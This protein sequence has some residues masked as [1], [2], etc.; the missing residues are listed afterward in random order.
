MWYEEK[1]RKKERES[2]GNLSFEKKRSFKSYITRKKRGEERNE[3]GHY[4]LYARANKGRWLMI[5]GSQDKRPEMGFQEVSFFNSCCNTMLESSCLLLD[6]M[7]LHQKKEFL[8]PG[9]RWLVIL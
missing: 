5:K 2:E 3:G 9:S 6:T 7:V 8:Q 1:E 4:L